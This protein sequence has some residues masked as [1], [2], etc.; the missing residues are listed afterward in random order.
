MRAITEN[1]AAN[2]LKEQFIPDNV[3]LYVIRGEIRFFDG[4]QS[5]TLKAGECGVARKNH[6]ARFV[7]TDTGERFQ[8]VLFC[9]DE[10]FLRRFQSKHQV[11]VPPVMTKAAVMKLGHNAL[12]EEFIRSIEPYR[13]GVMELDEAFEDLKYEELLIILLKNQPELAGLFFDFGQPGKIGLEAFMNRNYRFNVNISRFAFLTGRSISAFKRDF[14]LVFGETPG[15]W[16][17]KKRLEEAHRLIVRQ[18]AKPSAIYLDLG[19]KSLSHFSV[20][21][22][23]RFGSPP[24]ALVNQNIARTAAAGAL[25]G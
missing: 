24:A 23:K 12:I 17:M 14:R 18:G 9:F 20:A 3:F 21:F 2:L 19:F 11:A 15:H 10:P 8:P 4:S 22:K 1:T 6:L 16:L 7:V 25:P 5:H 13:R